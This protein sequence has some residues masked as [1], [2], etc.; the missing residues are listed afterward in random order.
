[1]ASSAL[2]AALLRRA[3]RRARDLNEGEDEED[4]KAVEERKREARRR[5][6]LRNQVR[7]S[8]LSASLADGIAPP[9]VVPLPGRSMLL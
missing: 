5:A 8:S 9:R 3:E 1:M 7:G 2:P 6:L 4:R